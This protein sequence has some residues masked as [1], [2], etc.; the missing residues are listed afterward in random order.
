MLYFALYCTLH[1]LKYATALNNAFPYTE[2]W[3]GSSHAFC[4]QI[5]KN[6]TLTT[7]EMLNENNKYKLWPNLYNQSQKSRHLYGFEYAIDAIWRNQHPTN[8]SEAKFLVVQSTLKSGFGSE[9]HV[10]GSYLA[11][12]MNL[13]RALLLHPKS[14][15][16]W[17]TD[18]PFCRHGNDNAESVVL[19]TECYFEPLSS[20]TLR[21]ALGN[22]WDD[23]SIWALENSNADNQHL[24][25]VGVSG[26]GCR[27][28][29][30]TNFKR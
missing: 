28:V 11:H 25:A 1:L 14:A 19:N 29:F 24:R 23:S 30:P 6:W 22:D 27:N 20:C 16:E 15:F 26:L 7:K 2:G 17:Q 4:V 21:D 3:H 13:N 5:R 18:V 10:L 9:I 8:C 12:A